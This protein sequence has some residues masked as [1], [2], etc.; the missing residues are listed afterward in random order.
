MGRTKG[1]NSFGRFATSTVR[2]NTQDAIRETSA[3]PLC[4]SWPFVSFVMNQRCQPAAPKPASLPQEGRLL[5]TYR[6]LTESMFRLDSGTTSIF[7]YFARSAVRNTEAS[8]TMTRL[9]LEAGRCSAAAARM[10]SGV[11]PFTSSS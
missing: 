8:P 4:P 2:I 1:Q 11:T 10:A 3:I 5:R 7:E 6:S 9:A